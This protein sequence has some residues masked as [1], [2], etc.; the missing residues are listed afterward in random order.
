MGGGGGLG[1]IFTRNTGGVLEG[2]SGVSLGK[3]WKNGC[4][5]CTLKPFLLSKLNVR[6]CFISASLITN[7][8]GFNGYFFF[9]GGGV[10]MTNRAM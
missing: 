8:D 7:V 10:K 3:F 1:L 4:K 6:S 9:L 2:V 5:Q